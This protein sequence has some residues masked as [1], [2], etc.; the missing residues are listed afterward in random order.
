[1]AIFY[2]SY[3]GGNFEKFP[4]NCMH[5]KVI[6]RLIR[7]RID[8]GVKSSHFRHPFSGGFIE[9]HSVMFCKGRK[10]LRILDASRGG[11]RPKKRMVLPDCFFTDK[12]K[13]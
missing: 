10:V 1:M 5:Q 13:N 6:K 9:V 7:N 8:S 12:T 2:T 11:Y 4:I 3:E